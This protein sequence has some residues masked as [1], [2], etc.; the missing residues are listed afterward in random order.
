MHRFWYI[1]V[2]VVIL[3]ILGAG[4]ARVQWASST[5]SRP[6]KMP[7]T[8]I[9]VPAPP[10][11]LDFAPRGYWLA[12]WLDAVRNVDR[13]ELTDYKGHSAFQADYSPVIG[14]SPVPEN[15]L[16]LK[17]TDSTGLWAAVNEELVPIAH[18]QNG[19]VLVPTKNLS[20]LR[21]RFAPK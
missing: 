11:P 3:A 15:L 18:L 12:C 16:D 10:A 6:K 9:W 8:A 13:C 4:V 2:V 14:L 19:A 1:G 5:P 7:A 20:E 17:P 21:Q